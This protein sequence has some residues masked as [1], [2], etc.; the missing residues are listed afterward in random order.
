MTNRR[1]YLC[2]R[3]FVLLTVI[4]IAGGERNCRVAIFRVIIIKYWAICQYRAID[5]KQN[6]A[7]NYELARGI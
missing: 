7:E 3:L 5:R 1:N 4:I 6:G 2:R